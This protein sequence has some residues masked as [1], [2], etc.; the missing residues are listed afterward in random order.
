MVEK[1]SYPYPDSRPFN[2][3]YQNKRQRADGPSYPAYTKPSGP[4]RPY[5]IKNCGGTAS[6]PTKLSASEVQAGLLSLL[7]QFVDEEP[8]S[9]GNTEVL[10][11]ARKLQELLSQRA[12]QSLPTSAKRDLDH[13]RPG[14]PLP[15]TLPPYT[16]QRLQRA[17]KLPPLPPVN[18][19]YLKESIFRHRSSNNNTTDSLNYERLEFLG[20]AYIEVISTRIIYCRFQHL[21]TGKQANLR[22]QLVKNESL[23]Q[24]SDAY[25]FGERIAHAGDEHLDKGWTKILA[26]VFEAYVAAIILADPENGFWV[27]EAW[28]TELWAPQLLEYKETLVENPEAKNELARLIMAPRVK[29]H[30]LDEKPMEFKNGVQKFFLGCY[31]TGWGYENQWLGSGEGQN[32]G[33]AGL[34]AASDAMQ[35]SKAIIEEC[36]RK[37]LELYPLALKASAPG[38]LT[39]KPD[40]EKEN[41]KKEGE[42]KKALAAEEEEEPYK[43]KNQTEAGEEKPKKKK[44]KTLNEDETEEI[45]QKKKDRARKEDGAEKVKEK[46]KKNKT[47]VD[48]SEIVMK[49]TF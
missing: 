24:L 35:R 6:K 13:R 42:K 10:Q 27:A 16:P 20:D 3:Q 41:V 46:K 17:S 33:Q 44:D 47:A 37:K 28:L 39:G 49:G 26:D 43:K 48:W 14:Q 5:N 9:N 30:Y 25:G 36:Q 8:S 38:E 34:A 40:P 18:E 12:S 1:R 11:Y 23:A 15:T 19:P 31:L 29:L 4:P 32:K 45:K 22:E 7:D 21:E 2:P